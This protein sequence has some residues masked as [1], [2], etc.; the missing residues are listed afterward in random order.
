MAPKTFFTLLSVLWMVAV[1]VATT[2]ASVGE[3][4]EAAGPTPAGNSTGTN[5]TTTVAPT[6][7]GNSTE[8][9]ATTTVAPTTAGNSTGTNAT[10]TVAPTT[11]GNSTGTTATTTVAPTT[12]GNSTGTNATTTVAPTTAGNSTETNATT[13][14]APT[15]APTNSPPPTPRPNPCD[16]N[17]CEDGSRCQATGVNTI[18]CL[19][20]I[21]Q[22]Y[23][24]NTKKC[25]KATV[26]PGQIQTNQ[27]YSE[28][29]ADKA[30]KEFID[31][32]A[33]IIS[34]L[35]IRLTTLP[36]ADPV[37]LELLPRD[38][39]SSRRS[40]RSS[41]EQLVNAV[42][43]ILFP[44]DSRVEEGELITALNNTCD[45]CT[46]TGDVTFEPRSQCD[47]SGCNI[48]D[49]VC[50][51]TTGVAICDCRPGYTP[52]PS[53]A[54]RCLAP[55]PNGQEAT[56]EGCVKCKFGYSGFNCEEEWQ[57]YLTI[58]GSVL[59]GLLL[60]S[61]VVIGVLSCKNKKSLKK[62]RNRNTRTTSAN[63]RRDS[64]SFDFS[65]TASGTTLSNG[66]GKTG[67]NQVPRIP[68]AT[69]NSSSDSRTNLEMSPGNSRQ[70][71]IPQS[72]LQNNPY[73]MSRSQV[74]P[75]AQSQGHQ[76]NSYEF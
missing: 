49:S 22:T 2:E 62:S 1:L 53:D 66:I 28:E 12:A 39:V 55:C 38:P 58:A 71:L 18:V 73:A 41:G 27:T 76:N 42:V 44:A 51:E 75:Y 8:T 50:N 30:S 3:T 34:D 21:G 54:R 13:A 72:R 17:P 16:S 9:N 46:V 36:G 33:E 40:R 74:N 56:D 48:I 19:C 4:D 59:G 24:D 35:K 6:T 43:Q 70:N 10:T 37:V 15:T 14:D 26:F 68:R 67:N 32:S 69:T 31:A 60:I 47:V 57:L 61:L 25:E 20:L 29:M 11:A 64:T 5:A 45:N 23:N 63:R 65:L 52:S 7:A